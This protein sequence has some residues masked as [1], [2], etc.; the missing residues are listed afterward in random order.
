VVFRAIIESSTA[1]SAT[2]Q[3][4]TISGIFGS[5][6][7]LD[8]VWDEQMNGTLPVSGDIYSQPTLGYSLPNPLNDNRFKFAKRVQVKN[9]NS[10]EMLVDFSY[11]CNK[12]V[13]YRSST[14]ATGTNSDLSTRNL[15][16][17]FAAPADV[18]PIIQYSMRVLFVDA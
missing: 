11:T 8:L 17:C 18:S 5:P 12:M 4:G 13:E 1:A 14:G 10:A 16:L 9:P 7:T 6:Y 3:G 15:L 2:L